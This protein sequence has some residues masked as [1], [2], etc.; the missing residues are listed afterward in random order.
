VDI[1]R[2]TMR[3]M[4]EG[5]SLAEIRTY[6]DGYYSRFGSPTDTERVTP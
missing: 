2:D 6:I 3:L 4:K 1:V 5:K